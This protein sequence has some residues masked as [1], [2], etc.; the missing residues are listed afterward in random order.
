MQT[1]IHHFT[2]F[3]VFSDEAAAAASGSGDVSPFKS[4][5]KLR[6]QGFFSG[7][8]M[9]L[10]A[11][12]LRGDDA[13]RSFRSLCKRRYKLCSKASVKESSHQ[14][15]ACRTEEGQLIQIDSLEMPVGVKKVLHELD[16]DS[17]GRKL[18]RKTYSRYGMKSVCL[19]KLTT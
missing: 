2:S 6:T 17:T 7:F 14:S 18:H 16:L 19:R 13:R 15:Y 8:L 1:I 3:R 10:S 11:V 5:V 9:L 12:A 4:T